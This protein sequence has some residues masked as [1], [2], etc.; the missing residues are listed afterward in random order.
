MKTI[1]LTLTF[2]A[3]LISCTIPRKPLYTEATKNNRDYEIS[4]LFEHDGCKVYRFFD[5]GNAVYFTSCNG[6]TNYMAD[7]ITTIKNT[8]RIKNKNRNN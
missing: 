7:S 8:T 1:A 4:Y 5:L 3:V 2:L 6:E